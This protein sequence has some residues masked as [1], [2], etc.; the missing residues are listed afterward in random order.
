MKIEFSRQIFQNS[1]EVFSK[2]QR[3][4]YE[5]DLIESR[6]FQKIWTFAP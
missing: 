6:S 5:N 3:R 2:L 4:S 1:M